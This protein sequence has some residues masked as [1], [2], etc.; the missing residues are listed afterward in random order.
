MER[1]QIL[2]VPISKIWKFLF[3]SNFN[4]V[5]F[6]ASSSLQW[7]IVDESI[8]KISYF[9][10]KLGPNS[11]ILHILKVNIMF[12]L[13][14]ILIY[15]FLWIDWSKSTNF[16]NLNFLIIDPVLMQF[17]LLA[18]CSSLWVV[19]DSIY[20]WTIFWWKI[21]TQNFEIN[22][23][24]EGIY[25]FYFPSNLF[26]FFELIVTSVSGCIVVDFVSYGFC[27]QFDQ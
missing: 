23:I 7:V 24:F 21:C 12:I 16:Q 26:V 20:Y 6:F 25:N 19:C 14:L 17:F 27:I 4:T 18:K 13:H 3:S 8:K 15:L 5:F 2:K 10:P 11:G 22:D 9:I 1:V